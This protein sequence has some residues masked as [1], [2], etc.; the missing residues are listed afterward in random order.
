MSMVAVLNTQTSQPFEIISQ[1]GAQ[2]TVLLILSLTIALL[3]FDSRY[4]SKWASSSLD[5][6]SN[7]LLV[8]FAAIVA[9][10]IMLIL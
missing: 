6:V 5:A 4:W 9:F 2:A 1:G 3:I 8:T 7:T 10:K